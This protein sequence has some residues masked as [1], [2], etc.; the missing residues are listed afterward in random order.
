MRPSRPLRRAL[1]ALLALAGAAQATVFQSYALPEQARRAQV[2]VQAS[3][4]APVSR[5]EGGLSWTVYPLSVTRTAAGSVDDLPQLDGR[6]ALYILSGMDEAP[7]FQAG[8]QAVLL[9]YK[10]RLDNPLVGFTQGAYRIRD[11]RVQGEAAANATPDAFWQRL[12]SLRE[13]GQ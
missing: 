7:T 8:E 1:A 3:L 5:E 12:V 4:G 9:L 10:G 2:I 11:G 13:G 6:P